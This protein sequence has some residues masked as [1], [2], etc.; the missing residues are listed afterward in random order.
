MVQS[1]LATTNIRRYMPNDDIRIFCVLLCCEV[2]TNESER[3]KNMDENDKIN[4]VNI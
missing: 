1:L 2:T 4:I 3:L